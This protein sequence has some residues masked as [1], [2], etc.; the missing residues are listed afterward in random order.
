MWAEVLLGKPAIFGISA[1]VPLPPAKDVPSA[2]EYSGRM[3][4]G[5][6]VKPSPDARKTPY[7]FTQ[8]QAIHARVTAVP[9]RAG[10]Q[11]RD[12]VVDAALSTALASVTSRRFTVH[13]QECPPSERIRVW[14]GSNPSRRRPTSSLVRRR[15]GERTSRGVSLVEP[16]VVDKA[17]EFSETEQPLRAAEDIGPGLRGRYD[18][19]CLAPS[20]MWGHGEPLPDLRDS[21]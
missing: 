9:G 17:P 18:L 5:A 2:V 7:L 1:A 20:F 13:P 15:L 4:G 14:S 16:S 11:C 3:L 6:V 10:C 8:S 12:A 21:Y 19:V